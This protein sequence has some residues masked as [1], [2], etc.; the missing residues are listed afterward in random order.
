MADANLS[1]DDLAAMFRMGHSK[2]YERV[3]ST[4][5]KA[6]NCYI[7]DCRMEAARRLLEDESLTVAEVAYKVGFSDPFYFGT[8]FKR[9]YGVTPSK[10]QKGGRPAAE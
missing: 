9:Q 7:R 3:K 5:G 2:F 4:T 8:C 10:Y 6:P 1:V